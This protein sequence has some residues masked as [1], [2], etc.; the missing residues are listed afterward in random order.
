MDTTSSFVYFV[1]HFK[2]L[3]WGLQKNLF[4]APYDWRIAP[5]FSDDF[6]PDFAQLIEKAYYENES[7]VTLV[8]FSLGGSMIQQFLTKHCLNEWK[9]KFIS[10]VIFILPAFTGFVQDLYNLWVKENPFAPFIHLESLNLCFEQMPEVHAIL[11]NEVV[12]KNAVIAYGPKGE[13]FKGKD[14]RKLSMNHLLFNENAR[15]IFNKTEKIIG[16]DPL[17]VKTAFF[18]EQRRENCNR[19]EFL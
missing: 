17:D 7:K 15:K 14:L 13:E 12:F 19:F 18:D 5:T 3:G 10:Q 11:P 16:V 1:E 6:W 2:N 8:G 4:V 9:S